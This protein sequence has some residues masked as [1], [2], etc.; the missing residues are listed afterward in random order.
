MDVTAIGRHSVIQYTA[1][2]STEYAHFAACTEHNRF[3][4]NV[5]KFY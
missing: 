2:I 4:I 5:I 3:V 1:M